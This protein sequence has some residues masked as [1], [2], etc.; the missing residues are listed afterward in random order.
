MDLSGLFHITV[1][2]DLVAG[3]INVADKNGFATMHLDPDANQSVP[4][5]GMP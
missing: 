2:D 3:A 1:A 4:Y 5:H